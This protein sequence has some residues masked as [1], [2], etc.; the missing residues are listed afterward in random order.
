MTFLVFG[1]LLHNVSLLSTSFIEEEHQVWYFLTTTYHVILLYKMYFQRKSTSRLYFDEDKTLVNNSTFDTAP[2]NTNFVRGEDKNKEVTNSPDGKKNECYHEKEPAYIILLLI[3]DRTLRSWNQTGMKWADQPD[4]GDWLVNP[5]NRTLLSSLT[6]TSLLGVALGM[7]YKIQTNRCGW[8]TF[9]IFT[10]GEVGVY[11]Y[12]AVTGCVNLPWSV[13]AS[14]K[15][16]IQFAQF[17]YICVLVLLLKSLFQLC[18]EKSKGFGFP[19][20]RSASEVLVDSYVLLITLLLRTHNVPLVALMLL[21][22]HVH[23]K[24]IWKR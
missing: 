8:L 6:I 1:L 15:A 12:R 14:V 3:F 16:G 10:A 18:Y 9:I 24:V 2:S 23:R 13:E 22:V 7:W 20:L 4:V 19:T 21:Q 17:V 5:K 11:L